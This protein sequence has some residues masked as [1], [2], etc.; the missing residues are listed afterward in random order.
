MVPPL[1]VYPALQAKVFVPPPTFH[2][3]SSAVDADRFILETDTAAHVW[4]EQSVC[5]FAACTGFLFCFSTAKTEWR[6]ALIFSWPS[7][8]HFSLGTFCQAPNAGTHLAQQKSSRQNQADKIE[9]P[10]WAAKI[11]HP[12]SSTK[13]KHAKSSSKNRANTNFPGHFYFIC[14]SPQHAKFFHFHG[15]NILGFQKYHR[16]KKISSTAWILVFFWFE[17]NQD[18]SGKI[19]HKIEHKIE[20]PKLRSKVNH[21]NQ[22]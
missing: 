11:K 20:Q 12:K 22:K 19:E 5:V 10:N 2:A 16:C 7:R 13:I 14:S 3:A 4:A 9:P 18:I 1:A 21:Q 6:Q 15:S 8:R 17:Q